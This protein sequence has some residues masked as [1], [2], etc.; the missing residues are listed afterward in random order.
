MKGKKPTT[1]AEYIRAAPDVG[2]PHLK[3]IYAILKSVAPDAEEAIKWNTPF[4]VEPR[5]LFAF[6]AFK[7]HCT[8]AP[9]AATL[10][11]FRKELK[12]YRTTKNYLQ[13]PYEEEVPE[14]LIRRMAQHCVATVSARE[15][16][17]FW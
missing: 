12:K 5:F 7:S 2:Q 8:F 17:S 3:Q 10:E 15:D 11:H 14:D 13:V 1:I 9:T 16:D 6:A 4:F